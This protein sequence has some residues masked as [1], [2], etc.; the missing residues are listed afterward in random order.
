MIL[1]VY[2]HPYPNRS[3]ANR[4]LLEAVRDL[5]GLE[6][7]SLYELYPDFGIDVEAE[8]AALTRARVL[9]WQH[10]L[11]WYSVPGLLKHWFD[12]VLARG[13]AHGAHGDALQGKTCLWVTTT[14][15]DEET[16][17]KH[18]MH[19]YPF[20]SFVPTVEQTARFCGMH[21]AA[22]RVVQGAHRVPETVLRAQAE[23]YRESLIALSAAAAGVEP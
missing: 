1:L 18:G 4:I 8:Q 19:R 2:A 20:E 12:K 7:R 21:W 11:Y 5:P 3:R 15:G 10:P 13:F 22:P 16:F 14:G 6:L 17:S 23:H 9:V